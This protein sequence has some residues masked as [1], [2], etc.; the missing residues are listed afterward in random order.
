MAIESLRCNNCGA[1]LDLNPKIKFFKCAHCGSTLTIKKSG[2]AIYTEVINEIKNNTEILIDNSNV[3]AIEKEIARLDREWM[4][5]RDKYKIKTKYS[6]ELPN[7]NTE[8]QSI[9]IMVVG[10]AF[11]V[12]WLNQVSGIGGNSGFFTLFG[13]IAIGTLIYKTVTNLSTA[14]SYRKA[15][16]AYVNRRKRLT[17]KL[18][19]NKKE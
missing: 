1:N 13:F 10:L 16:D 7:D 4:I 18:N 14:N 8:I 17:D 3:D 15:E 19:N 11:M 5:E 6:S 9:G 2:N 12:F